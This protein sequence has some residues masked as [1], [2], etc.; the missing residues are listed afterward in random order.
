MIEAD[1]PNISQQIV[2]FADGERMLVNNSDLADAI[3]SSRTYPKDYSEAMPSAGGYAIAAI[4]ERTQSAIAYRAEQLS[5]LPQAVSDIRAVLAKPG[6][7]WQEFWNVAQE[8]EVIKSDYLA[9]LTTQET[10]QNIS[11]S[12][13]RNNLIANLVI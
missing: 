10:W 7:T 5:M 6:C 4:E 11:M 13:L 9:E 1:A 2:T 3:V 8:Y 12:T